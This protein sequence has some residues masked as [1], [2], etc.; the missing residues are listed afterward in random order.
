MNEDIERVKRDIERIKEIL[1]TDRVDKVSLA[2]LW[3]NQ[4]ALRLAKIE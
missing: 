3:L 2:M 4:A 1:K